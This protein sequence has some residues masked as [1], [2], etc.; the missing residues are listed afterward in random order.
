MPR[1]RAQFDPLTCDL[2][3]SPL[4]WT[5]AQVA[6]RLQVDVS[7]VT[8]ACEAGRLLAYK[9]LGSNRW[10]IPRAALEADEAK[11]TR[12]SFVGAGLPDLVGAL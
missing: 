2:R 10:R 6:A 9:P 12:R 4:W 5:P 1:T 7:C 3:E 8:R 11:V